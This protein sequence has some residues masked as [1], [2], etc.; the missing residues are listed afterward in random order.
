MGVSG[1]IHTWLLYLT[2][3]FNNK[4][5]EL[6]RNSRRLFGKR[7]QDDHQRSSSFA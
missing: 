7:D 4:C 6:Y 2:P 3:Q 5:R 1:Q